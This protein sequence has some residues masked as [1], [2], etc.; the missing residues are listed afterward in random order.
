MP[1]PALH[2]LLLGLAALPAAAQPI[3]I[4]NPSFEANFAANGTFPVQIPTSW[5][6]LDPGGIIDQSTNA[7]GVLN[8]TGAAFFPAGVPDGRN[9]ALIYLESSGGPPVSLRQIVGATLQPR[10]RYAL[11][12]GVGNIASG[13][14][15]PPFDFRFYD[16]DGFPGYSVQ[17]RA[18]GV[19]LAEDFNSLGATLAEGQFATTTVVF[20]SGHSHA[21]LGQN[22]EVRLTNLNQ[23]DTPEDPGIE[24][25]FDM[26]TLIA[27]PIC[28]ADF[29]ADLVVS[30]QDIFD[31]LAAYFSG[32]ASADVSGGGLSVQD[33]F[34]YLAAY[35]TGCP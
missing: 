2:A 31:F 12:V 8:P 34:D 24:V 30:V 15:L 29:N 7:V 11:S 16:L 4:L 9:A 32:D 21:Q 19:L 1:T 6:L 22:L 14:G 26:V 27:A 3:T 5:D 33:I 10:T 25:D 18:G 28:A 17:L 35:F 20:A 23:I 13:I